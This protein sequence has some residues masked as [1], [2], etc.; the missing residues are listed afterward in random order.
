M[1]GEAFG[2]EASKP[3]PDDLY[4]GC[5]CYSCD[6]QTWPRTG[7]IWDRFPQR[8]NLCPYCGSKRCRGAI[9]HRRPEREGGCNG[10]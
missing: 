3:Y 2:L 8:M 6:S 5:P 9:N 4:P 1:S 10:G 7:T